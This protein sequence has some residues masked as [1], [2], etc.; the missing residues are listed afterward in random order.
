MELDFKVCK[1]GLVDEST[2]FEVHVKLDEF[3][4]G[5]Y[6]QVRW[7]LVAKEGSAVLE[8]LPITLPVGDSIVLEG[9]RLR[10]AGG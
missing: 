8:S 7:F 2:E 5:G 9:I 1:P 10:A 3:A 6:A 4:N